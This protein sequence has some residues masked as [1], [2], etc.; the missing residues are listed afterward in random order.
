MTARAQLMDRH[1]MSA[2][3]LAYN[4]LVNADDAELVVEQALD[5]ALNAAVAQ[6][7]SVWR[8]IADQTRERARRFLDSR[9]P[10][11]LWSEDFSAA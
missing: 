4:I 8:C 7:A 6:G 10:T 11:Q 1:R 3:A 2:F 9:A 5:A